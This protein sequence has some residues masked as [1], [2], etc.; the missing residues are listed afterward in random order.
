MPVHVGGMA[1]L[2]CTL[3]FVTYAEVEM[4]SIS[5]EKATLRDVAS[6]LSRVYQTS[7]CLEQVAG[8]RWGEDLNTT[9]IEFD[10]KGQPLLTFSLDNATL[11]DAL[12]KVVSLVP[13]YSWAIDPATDIVNVYPI[14][15]SRLGWQID[16]LEIKDKTFVAVFDEDIL[17]LRENGIT[18]FPGRGNLS[19]LNTPV[20]LAAKH[21]TAR[22]ALNALC[23]QLPFK[24]RWEV[25]PSRPGSTDATLMFQGYGTEP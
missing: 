1:L 11:E 20:S 16:D 21:I 8:V 15:N 7:I 4:H 6:K 25:F 14:E 22:D 18:F 19:W 17:N 5:F 3:G 23:K 12:G 13:G 2:F 10:R 24:A 9:S